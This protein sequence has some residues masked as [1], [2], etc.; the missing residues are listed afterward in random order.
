MT[1]AVAIIPAHYASSRFPGKMLADRTGQPLI[2]HVFERVQRAASIARTIVA[3]DDARIAEAVRTFGGEAVM[4]RADHPNGTSRL[5]EVAATLS[6]EIIVN[7][8]GDEPEIDPAVIDL[9]VKELTNHPDCPVSTV[10][11]PF[12]AD[13][14]SADPNIVKVVLDQRG[15]ALYF[16]RA[17]VP[18]NRDRQGDPAAPPLRHVGLYVYRRGFLLEYVAWPE[19]PLER[20]EKLEQLRILE[21]G[22]RIAVAISESRHAGIDTPEQY[23]A[24]VRRWRAEHGEPSPPAA[25]HR[26]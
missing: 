25:S 10:A 22:R 20:T 18:H 17:L 14:D 23:E 11:S 13:E 15:E 3:T 2:R 24:F 1:T 5:A 9:A 8:Q 12:G 6:D 4:T 16:S 21:H 7:V 26:D 19:T